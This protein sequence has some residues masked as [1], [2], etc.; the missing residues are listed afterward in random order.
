MAYKDNDNMQLNTRPHWAKDWEGLTLGNGKSERDARE[1]L[2]TVSY[3]DA[4]PDFKTK[5][6]EI[7][8]EQG[9]EWKIFALGSR[10]ICGIRLYI[11]W[12]WNAIFAVL[13]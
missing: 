3:K 7:G 2:R 8:K 9:W 4:I 5:L 6:A 10:T 12:R 1:Y 11:L 13:S